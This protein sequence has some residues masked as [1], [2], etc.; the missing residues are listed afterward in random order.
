MTI[1]AERILANYGKANAHHEQW[2]SIY[3]DAY[4]LFMPERNLYSET[5]EGEDRTYRVYTS[6][7]I[8]AANSFVNRMQQGLTPPEKR[9]MILK[10]GPSIVDEAKDEVNEALDEITNR[11]FNIIRPS[12]FNLAI[13]ELYYDLFIGTGC[14]LILEGDDKNPVRYISVPNKDVALEEGKDGSIQ[15]IYRLFKLKAELVKEYWPLST[16]EPK[17]DDEKKEFEFLETTL[18][19]YQTGKWD[20]IV[21]DKVE[22]RTI[23]KTSM[24]VNPWVIVRWTKMAKEVFGR[25]PALQALPEAK[26]LNK[27][28]EFSIR[29]MALNSVGVFTVTDPN[30]IDSNKFRIYPGALNPVERNAGP[31]GPSVQRLDTGGNPQLEQYNMQDTEMTI[32]KLAFDNQ[33]PPLAGQPKSATE[34]MERMRELQVDIG[35][36][37]GRIMYEMIRPIVIRTLYIMW[38]KGLIPPELD[39]QNI[40]DFY[41]KIEMLSPIARQQA[42]EDVQNITNAMQLSAMINPEGMIITYDIEAIDAYLGDKLGVPAKFIRDKE[43]RELLKQQMQQ[44]AEAQQNKQLSAEA[45]KE[46]M[47]NEAKS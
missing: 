19:N 3:D 23:F 8:I 46:I 2:R 44:S 6:A 32:K 9:W 15:A 29:G 45:G 20:Y 35:G 22:K 4:N 47:V 13:S 24:D 43:D 30:V 31:N 21:V 25:G 39:I 34:I 40:D 14:M 28:K 27:Q 41:V 18:L 11:F 37:F 42:M 7:G 12:N 17:T 26:M 5:S 10:A 33:L 36:A 38:R 1:S 16:F